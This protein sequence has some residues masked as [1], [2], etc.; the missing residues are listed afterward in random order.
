MPIGVGAALLIG[1]AV[2][3]GAAVASAALQSNAAKNAAKK[4][5]EGTDRAL[6]VQQQANAP[7][8]QLGQQAAGRLAGR[9]FEPFAQQFRPGAPG[10]PAPIGF[11]PFQPGAGQPQMTLGS[12]GQP[13]PSAPQ[14][15]PGPGMEQFAT[16]Q[17]PTG[18][19]ARIP[20]GPMLEQ[21]LAR[22]ARRMA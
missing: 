9:Q 12:I 14:G 18:E 4:Q 3:G 6:Q 20:V 1:S 7:Y 21:A 10:Q 17:A 15:Q 22:G 5:Q 11:Q 2:S 19:M 16:V 13:P 8:M